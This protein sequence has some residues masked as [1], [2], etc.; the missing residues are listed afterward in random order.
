[1]F[2]SRFAILFR[3]AVGCYSFLPSRAFFR[4]VF[5]VTLCK[6]FLFSCQHLHLMSEEM[7]KPKNYRNVVTFAQRC[8]LVFVLQY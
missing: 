5:N 3:Y 2:A 6:N 4:G 1:M 7:F 8:S